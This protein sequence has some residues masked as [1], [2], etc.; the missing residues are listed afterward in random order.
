MPSFELFRMQTKSYRDEVLPP[1]VKKRL[2]VE[3]GSTFGWS[4]WVGDSG[5]VIGMNTFGMSAPDND[6]FEYFGFTVENII[7]RVKQLLGK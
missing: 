1:D 2:A 5:D 3:A 4:E 6:L 7:S